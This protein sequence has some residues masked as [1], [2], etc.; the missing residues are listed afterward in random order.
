MQKMTPLELLE[1]FSTGWNAHDV[2]VLLEC[3]TND[4]IFFGSSGAE[5]DGVIY[6]GTK[7]L[8]DS[9]AALWATFPDA[10]WNDVQHFISGDRAVTEWRFTGTKTDGSKINVRGC[11]VFLIRGGKIAVKDTFRK[12]IL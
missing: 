6:K 4:G 3:M 5:P 2:D 1:K 10:V 8:R 11:D 7:E 12:Q 9:F